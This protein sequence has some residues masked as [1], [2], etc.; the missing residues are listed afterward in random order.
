MRLLLLFF[1]G[2][3]NAF[4]QTNDSIKVIIHEGTN[5]AVALSPDKSQMAVDLQGTLW[6]IPSGGGVARAITDPF[7]DS[8]QP[9]WSPDGNSLMFQSYRDG[10]WHIWRV[11]SDGKNLKQLT[12]GI[13]DD[14]EPQ[15]S[16]DGKKILFSSDRNNNYDIWEIDLSTG[17]F[18]ALTNHSKNDYNPAYSSDG[19]WVAY[20]SERGSKPSVYVRT[21]DGNESEIAQGLTSAAAPSWSPDGKS[22]IYYASDG[23]ET[24]LFQADYASKKVTNFTDPKEDAFPFRVNWVSVNE[25]IYTAD[26]LIKR[27]DLVKKNITTISWEATV[28]L[29]RPPYERKKYDFDNSDS[30]P[31]KGVTSPA[32]SPDGRSVI[33]S[34]LGNLWHQ[35][36]KSSEPVKLTDNEFVNTH[37]AWSPDGKQIAFV[38]D[39]DG[40]FDVWVRDIGSGSERQ[41]THTTSN[42]SLPTWSPDGKSIAYLQTDGNT[43]LSGSL[44]NV[45]D[46]SSGT[47]R[48]IHDVITTPSQP[49][50][51]PDGQHIVLGALVPFSSRYREGLNKLL[52]ISLSGEPDRY[53]SP[54][55]GI[56]IGS[57]MRNGPVWSPDGQ[58]IVYNQEG[59]LWLLPVTPAGAVTGPARR[60]TTELSE[61]PSWSGNSKMLCYQSA[62]QLKLVTVPGG[63]T[64]TIPV[65]LT[66]K[67]HQPANSEKI[68][69]A[70]KLFDGKSNGYRTNVDVIIMGNRIKEIVPHRDHGNAEVVDA[71]QQTVI[72]GMFDMHAHQSEL[73]G[74]KTGGGWLAFGITSVR[75]PGSDPYDAVSRKEIWTSGVRRGPRLFFTGYL[76]DGNRVYYNIAGSNTGASA[77]LELGRSV[78]LGFDMLKTYVR[79]PD[80]LQKRYVEFGHQHGMPLSSH[81][82]YPST[83]IGMDAIEHIGAT[84]RRGY[85]PVRSA[86]G[87][88]YQDVMELINKSRIRVTPTAA[89]YGG[90]NILTYQDPSLFKTTQYV[91]IY[92]ESYRAPYEA[93]VKKEQADMSQEKAMLT[94]FGITV[95]KLIADGNHITAGTDAPFMPYGLSIQLEMQT[96][97]NIL[98]ISPFH[99]LQSATLWAA[100]SAGVDKDLGS[101]ESGKLADLVI[102]DGDPLKSIRDAMNVRTVISNGF[103]YRVE[104]LLQPPGKN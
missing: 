69:H 12:F 66:W 27:K 58:W 18:R 29:H 53:L 24:R 84:S 63:K 94:G 79:M 48:K 75:E 65:K 33:Y 26:G 74:E 42:E 54:A 6:I 82:I 46:V 70:G 32:I 67:P 19:K 93:L 73:E 80:Y 20:I 17:S 34:A 44:L 50:W 7:G 22:I 81:E 89:L 8:R 59:L 77:D 95:K 1:L 98:G 30:N 31:V 62:D 55:E 103:V 102:V 91:S 76:Q 47:I 85:S 45:I 97:V 104:Q 37:P 100:E 38:S 101:V 39:R 57:R 16:P 35:P 9:S 83:A 14:R 56:T 41:L 49:S 52:F 78:A 87:R 10:G 90:F 88:S 60:I 96:Y 43:L 86:I 15:W 3:L 11:D 5:M 13:Y 36:L 64:E 61:N 2:A 21:E 25:V 71:T 99:A 28:Y 23:V 68:V 51:S 40:S 72:P 92:P 4:S